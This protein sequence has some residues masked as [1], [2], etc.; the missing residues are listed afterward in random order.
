MV[1]IGSLG[2]Q[3]CSRDDL[4]GLGDEKRGVSRETGNGARGT[5]MDLA[6]RPED[7]KG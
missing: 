3:I 6:S 4:S 1:V 2:L 7:E 5:E